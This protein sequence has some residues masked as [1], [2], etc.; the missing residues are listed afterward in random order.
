MSDTK[1]LAEGVQTQTLEYVRSSQEAVVQAV[2]AWADS[3]QQLAPKASAFSGRNDLPQ[4][5]ELVDSVFDFAGDLLAAQREFAHQLLAAAAPA[6]KSTTETAQ[7]EA[8]S[9]Q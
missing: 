8:G 3:V 6:V 4:P 7:E 5:V 2:Q 9:E 1:S